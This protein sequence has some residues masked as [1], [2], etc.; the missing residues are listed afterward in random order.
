MQVI[1]ARQQNLRIS[2]TKRYTPTNKPNCR[3]AIAIENIPVR[4]CS[5]VVLAIWAKIP[6][7]TPAPIP[8]KWYQPF[9]NPGWNA[10]QNLPL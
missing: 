4:S 8:Y 9:F 7:P 3:K 5:V 6:A 10:L 1:G 2:F